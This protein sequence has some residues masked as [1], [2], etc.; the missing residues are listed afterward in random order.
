MRPDVGFFEILGP[1]Q[2]RSQAFYRDLFDWAVKPNP[3]QDGYAMVSTSQAAGIPGGIGEHPSPLTRVYVRA[4]ALT[5]AIH[6]AE[7]LGGRLVQ[8]PRDL[9]GGQGSVA[10]I[11]DPACVEIGLW[12]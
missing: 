6:R 12:Q 11:A 9:P 5:D 4:Q 2:D 8:E 7:A 3:D 1:D 10:I